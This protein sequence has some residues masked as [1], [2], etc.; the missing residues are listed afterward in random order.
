[1]K[2]FKVRLQGKTAILLHSP[3]GMD[4]NRNGAKRGEK[5]IDT[6]EV[7]AAKGLYWMADKSSIGFPSLNILRSAITASTAWKIG[8]KSIVPFMAGSVSI[9]EEM[10]PFGTLEYE[11]DTR[12]AVVQKQGI[13]RSRPKLPAGWNLSFEVNVDGDAPAELCKIL[14]DIFAEA[15]RRVGLGDFR[16][17]KRGPFGKFAVIEFTEVPN[18]V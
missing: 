17:E 6:P 15:G 13:L 9:D 18:S 11:I 4:R 8:K 1:M 5:Q 7:E 2:T 16:P 14:P 10:I 3:S 12:R